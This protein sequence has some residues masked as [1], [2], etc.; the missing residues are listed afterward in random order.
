[1]SERNQKQ[2]CRHLH[3]VHEEGGA[4][5]SQGTGAWIPLSPWRTTVEQISSSPWWI[6]HWSTWTA[7]HGSDPCLSSLRRA[8]AVEGHWQS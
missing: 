3:G 1:M 7:S 2:P 4:G 6:H 8:A 5:G